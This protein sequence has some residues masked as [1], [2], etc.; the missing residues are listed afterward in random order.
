MQALKGRKQITVLPSCS[1]IVDAKQ[2]LFNW[3]LGPLKRRE[4][5]PGTGN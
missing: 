1:T 3:T 4:I 5:M 2:Y